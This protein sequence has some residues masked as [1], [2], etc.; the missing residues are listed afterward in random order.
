MEKKI[1]MTSDEFMFNI[2][3]LC[4]DI[5][6]SQKRD[7]YVML[8]SGANYLSLTN[9]WKVLCDLEVNYDFMYNW[10][11]SPQ[12]FPCLISF[13]KIYTDFFATKGI[14]G[15]STPFRIAST[16]GGSQAAAIAFSYI[17]ERILKKVIKVLAIGPSY[18]LY[19]RL[20]DKNYFEF[21][22]CLGENNFLPKYENVKECILS[23][24]YEIVLLT[25]PNN[26]TGE[27]F[28]QDEIVS[29]VS[30]VKKLN[31]IMIVDIVPQ[32]YITEKDII[33]IESIIYEADAINN[34]IIVNSFSKTEGV[35]GFRI[36][37]LC[38]SSD[39]IEFASNYQLNELM[40]VPVFP[41]FPVVFTL[42]FRMIYVSQ[43]KV[44]FKSIDVNKLIRIGKQ[45][46][47]TTCAIP[48]K[49]FI[50]LIYNRF[51]ITTFM[52]DYQEYIFQQLQKEKIISNNLINLKTVLKTEIKC[53]SELKNGFN[54]VVKLNEYTEDEQSFITN[55]LR[56]T[57]V[58]VL[59]E[60]C[61]NSTSST[62]FYFRISLAIDENRFSYAIN[63][64][65]EYLKYRKE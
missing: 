14:L 36:G 56:H 3:D 16:G 26:P 17:R 51:D 53:T 5:Y 59:T 62:E 40:N 19:E 4:A 48:N 9:M 30:L 60:S 10:Y 13:L 2:F 28:S 38:G 20:C 8:S 21:E 37:Y 18:S 39:L 15:K 12:G 64:V 45:I 35:P 63:R 65:S 6:H 61:F 57:S 58:S 25:I 34:V 23:N 42:L 41:V 27:M 22:V 43:K 54:V 44:E 33:N 32:M 31:K 49:D 55:L 1:G 46:I 7:E 52:N 29:I 50:S 11:T 47:D 24:E